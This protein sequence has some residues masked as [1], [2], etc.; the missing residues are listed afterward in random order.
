[1]VSRH[2]RSIKRFRSPFY[3]KVVT[4]NEG[5]FLRTI[6]AADRYAARLEIQKIE[7]LLWAEEISVKQFLALSFR[8]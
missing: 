4:K 8:F 3:F 6:E 1:M 5:P 7:H 2:C